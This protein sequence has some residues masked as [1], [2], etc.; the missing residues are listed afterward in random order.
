MKYLNKRD[1]FLKNYNNIL[2]IKKDYIPNESINEEN[3][4]A[5]PFS[6]DIG[7][8]DSLLGRLINSAIRKAKIGANLIRIKAVEQRLR[9]SMDELLLNTSVAELDENDKKLYAKA[10]IT[11]YLI[12]LQEGVEKG[13]SMDELKSLTETAINAV[14]S[15]KDLEDKNELL[16]QLNEWSKFLNEFK[17]EE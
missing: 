2:N 3:D 8:G 11:T 6:N 13:S 15:N 4:N 5:G 1:E 7:W 14:E 10:L 17:E 16:R 9:D 12:A